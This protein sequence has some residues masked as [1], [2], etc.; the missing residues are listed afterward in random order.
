[1]LAFICDEAASDADSGL[2]YAAAQRR[3]RSL[4]TAAALAAAA[5]DVNTPAARGHSRALPAANGLPAADGSAVGRP[6]N[7][8]FAAAALLAAAC[9]LAAVAAVA[10]RAVRRRGA[11]DTEDEYDAALLA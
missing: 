11:G 1:M 9:M 2:L 7:A 6:R 5:V 3:P 4:P 8:G 10:V